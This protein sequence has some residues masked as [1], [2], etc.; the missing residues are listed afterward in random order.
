MHGGTMA[1]GS[2][3]VLIGGPS[4][5]VTLGNPN[6]GTAACGAAKSTRHTPGRDAQ[7][8][9]NCG[10]ESCRAMINKRRAEQG[11][12]PATEDE[13][14]TEAIKAGTARNHPGGHDHGASG[15]DG[16][17]KVL[18]ANGIPAETAPQ[19]SEAIQ[20]AAAEGKGV[21]IH[22]HPYHFGD[23]VDDEWHHWVTVTGV[24]YDA[25]GNVSAVIVNDTGL[26][27]CGL[28][29]TPAQFHKDLVP[30][31]SMVVTKGRVW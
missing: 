12:P 2:S 10:L 22:I 1:I 20:Q 31:A 16:T 30:G 19:S 23:Y 11:L 5:G 18:E 7:S 13:V 27:V 14:L 8:Y 24:E 15:G 29:L 3:N 17:A 28:H 26:G 4:A 25:N 9:G 6:A 21:I